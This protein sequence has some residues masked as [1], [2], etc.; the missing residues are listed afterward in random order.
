MVSEWLVSLL[1]RNS[2]THTGEKYNHT[3]L[4]S[5]KYLGRHVWTH[6]LHWTESKESQRILVNREVINWMDAGYIKYENISSK[7]LPLI[8]ES[9]SPPRSLVHSG[10]SP[11]T[12][13][14]L[15][16]L[17]SILSVGLQGFS[18]FPSP[19][20]RWGF[21]LP[22]TPPSVYFP[23]QVPLSFPPNLWLFSS[24]SQVGLRCPHLGTLACWPFWVMWTVSW[25]FYTFSFV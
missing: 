20:T 12:S 7:A 11:P 21:H 18:L 25:V 9:L 16:L 14:F 2:T 10:G 23:S 13:Y 22:P 6:N 3:V 8:P 24:L 1:H 4:Y 5:P 15:R 17:L 19:N